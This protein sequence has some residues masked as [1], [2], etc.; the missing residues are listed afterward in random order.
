M[1]TLPWSE[2]TLKTVLQYRGQDL[3]KGPMDEHFQALLEASTDFGMMTDEYLVG[4]IMARPGLP[5]RER[6]MIIIATLLANR[7]AMGVFGHMK[8]ALNLGITREEVLEIIIQVGSYTGWPVGTEIFE[9]F[10]KAYP[11]YLKT[12]AE[13]FLQKVESQPQ[14]P[15]REKAL[16]VMA[17]LIAGRFGKRLHSQILNSLDLGITKEEILETIMQVTPFAGW[18]IGVEAILVAKATFEARK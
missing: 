6:S 17:V 14:L 7:F 5:M 11:G 18:P 15:F 10:E 8:W 12:T 16:I 4:D 2:K 3:T 9:L 1:N 13:D